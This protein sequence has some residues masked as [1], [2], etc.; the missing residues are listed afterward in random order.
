MDDVLQH[1]SLPGP[2]HL[3]SATWRERRDFG[4]GR[5]YLYPQDFE[6]ADVAQQYLPDQL[7][8]A[9]RHYYRPS[10]QGY[11]RV[12]GER[13]AA[14]TAARDEAAARGGA[15]RAAGPQGKVNAM[16]VAGGVMAQRDG[17]RR[18]MADRQRREAGEGS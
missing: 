18:E 13:M 4:T 7:A 1:G 3:R 15:R 12:I 17:K 8:T 5:G 2:N 10:E 11:E 16:K 6:G 9:G 14:R